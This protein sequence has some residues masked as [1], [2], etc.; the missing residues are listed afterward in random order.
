D[1]VGARHAVP[2][3][4][5]LHIPPTVQG[6]LAAR[7][8]RLA[9]DE[10]A[11]LQH[12]SVIGRQFPVSVIRQ[13]IPQ[14][15]A[16]LYRLLASLQRKEFLYEQPAFPEVEYLF[17]HALTQE[18]AYNSVLIERRKVLH[19]Q[20]GQAIEEVYRGQLDEHYRELAHHYSQ[21]SNT[22][23]A[24]EYL[25]KAGQQAVQRS[26]N[27]E[28]I[29]H[30]TTALELLKTL[31]D[32]PER[33]RQE[34]GLQIA[35][36]LP[37]MATKGFAA[38]EVEAVFARAR[39]LSQHLGE[40]PQ[41]ASALLGLCMF[42]STKGKYDLVREIVAQLIRS[43][44]RNPHSPIHIEASLVLGIATFFLGEFPVAQTQFAQGWALYDS[45]PRTA[46][47]F[48]YWKDPAIV[49]L[50]YSSWLLWFFGYPDQSLAKSHE[51]LALAR[52]VSHPFSLSLA[53]T[54]GGWLRQFR[55]EALSIQEYAEPLVALSREYDFPFFLA[56]GV[57]QEGLVSA[58]LR[59]SEEGLLQ[60]HKGMTAQQATGGENGRPYFFALLA[61][62]YGK[63][64]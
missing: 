19:E 7:I 26:A 37:L 39:E 32:T 33:T 15:E 20:V 45:Q 3:P 9:P 38:P 64:G 49:H 53:L 25:Q 60:I 12:L 5:I 1:A 11:L 29:T 40:S 62:E 30:L 27:T 59:K 35:L 51:A 16:D 4:Q 13:V 55:R 61:E 44:Q 42:Y 47:E 57:I 46:S 52:R 50:S 6:V 14:P 8:D 21:S 43:S 24:I 48:L 41:L 18:V 56:A 58:A 23:K 36:G 10:K 2:L 34:L 31:P 28:A 17:K 63:I 22:E 54:M